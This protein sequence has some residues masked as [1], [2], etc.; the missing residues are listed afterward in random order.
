MKP[1]RNSAKA[2]IVEHD[3][4][5]LTK[6]ADREGYFYLF[7]GGGQE[8]FETLQ[9]AVVRE[10][11]EE[12]GRLVHVEDIVFVREYIGRNH[13]FAE[14]DSDAHQVEFYFRCRLAEEEVCGRFEGSNPDSDQVGVEWVELSRLEEIRLYPAMLGVRLKQGFPQPVYIGD[15]N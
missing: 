9:E 3:R 7:P 4:V 11:M 2:V 1:I 15:V 14:W 8:K 13:Q 5:L 12:I 6:N 10:C